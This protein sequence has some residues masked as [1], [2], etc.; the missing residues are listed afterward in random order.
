MSFYLPP[1]AAPEQEQVPQAP[2]G[3][4]RGATARWLLNLQAPGDYQSTLAIHAHYLRHGRY[5]VNPQTLSAPARAYL[6]RVLPGTVPWSP[7]E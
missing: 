7:F 6:S 5:P 4:I 3:R 2:Q 1:D